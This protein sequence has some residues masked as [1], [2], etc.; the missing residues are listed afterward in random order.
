MKNRKGQALVEFILIIPVFAFLLF[1]L[2][3]F[4]K[5]MYEKITLQNHLEV[6]VDLYKESKTDEMN[7]YL[8]NEKITFEAKKDN[9]FII[10]TT[11]KKMNLITP[12]IRN[13]FENPYIIKESMTIVDES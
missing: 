8:N 10:I 12:G 3:D 2:I 4:G 11:T 13:L 5:I 9:Q 1:G 7:N 6:V